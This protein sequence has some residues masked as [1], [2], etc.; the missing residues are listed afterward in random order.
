MYD[1]HTKAGNPGDVI[2]HVALIAAANV[3]MQSCGNTFHYADTYAGYAF[4]PIKSKGEWQD[5]IGAIHDNQAE[6]RNQDVRFWRELWDCRYGLEGSVYPGSSIFMRKLCMKNG[7][8]FLARLWDISPAVI[9]Q[10][11]TAY[12]SN[13]A[14]INDRAVT[15]EDF[16]AQ[17]PDLL[18]IDPPDFA[19]VGKAL[20]F[21]DVADNVILWLPVTTVDGTETAASSG[22]FSLCNDKGLQSVT[23]I[24]GGNKNTRGCRLIY[25]LSP[26][27]EE[28]VMIAVSEVSVGLNWQVR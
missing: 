14:E 16:I 10:L 2:K 11:K 27:A 17:K 3:I 20:T 25:K 19:D 21:F 15:M 26:P 4:N 7:V 8:R 9:T 13:E 18:L 5:G 1:H 12:T 28:A 23:A 22:A 24:W 6:I